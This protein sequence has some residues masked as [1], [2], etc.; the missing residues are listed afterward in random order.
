MR[1]FLHFVGESKPTSRLDLITDKNQADSNIFSSPTMRTING[2]ASRGML[3][4]SMRRTAASAKA[5]KIE[6]H[7]C[8][9]RSVNIVSCVAAV[10]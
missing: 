10:F 4:K 8:N 7:P 5:E 2:Y 1:Y 3:D 9:V 6:K